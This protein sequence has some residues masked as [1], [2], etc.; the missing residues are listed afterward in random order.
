[1]YKIIYVQ[2]ETE[3]EDENISHEESQRG[4][5]GIDRK[6]GLQQEPNASV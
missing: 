3:N 6:K 1:M 4:T 2:E 5:S